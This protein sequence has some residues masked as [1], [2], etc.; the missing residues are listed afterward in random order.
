MSKKLKSLREEI[1]DLKLEL[2]S[3]EEALQDDSIP[4]HGEFRPASSLASP[5]NFILKSPNA[6]KKNYNKNVKIERVKI[7]VFL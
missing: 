5:H 3:E 2:L 4:V 6:I 1:S 7:L